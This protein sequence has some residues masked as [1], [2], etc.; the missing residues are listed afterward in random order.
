ME[1]PQSAGLEMDA[2][3]ASLL[4]LWLLIGLATGLTFVGYFAPIR[5]LLGQLM[6]GTADGWAYFWIGLFTLGT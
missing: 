4:L 5:E 6:D 1:G 2:N 3:A